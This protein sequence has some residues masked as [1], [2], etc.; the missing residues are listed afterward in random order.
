MPSVVI[1]VLAA[2]LSFLLACYTVNSTLWYWVVLL[3]VI[4]GFCLLWEQDIWSFAFWLIL[5][6]L[7][8]MGYVLYPFATTIGG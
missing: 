2:M 6:W 8:V 3:Y 4:G 7:T 1:T 5:I